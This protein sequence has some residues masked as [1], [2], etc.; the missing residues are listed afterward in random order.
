[1]L[2]GQA[3]EMLS[4]RFNRKHA[5]IVALL[6][7][8]VSS[9]LI[10]ARLEPDYTLTDAAFN[11]GY[12][13]LPTALFYVVMDNLIGRFEVRQQRRLD[14]LRRLRGLSPDSPAALLDDIVVGNELRLTSL[15]GAQLEGIE[16][17]DKRIPDA[18]I[19][20]ANA[21]RCHLIDCRILNMSAK[22]ASFRLAVFERCSFFSSSFQESD[23]S[24]A[25]FVSCE[26][27]GRE[28]FRG[29]AMSDVRFVECSFG[30][31]VLAGAPSA[32][33]KFIGCDGISD[34]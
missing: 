28:Y 10:R 18:S 7:V 6:T 8:G 5:I 16:I 20:G 21:D 29:A 34:E 32:G 3:S 15:S 24:G 14:A 22:A 12:E 26:F 30:P 27:Q 13:A 31:G 11:L 33:P 4:P 17:R 1:M 2:A 19:D 9:V 23:L 25:L